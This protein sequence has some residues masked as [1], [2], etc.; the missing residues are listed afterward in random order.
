MYRCMDFMFV[1]ICI[2]I[3]MNQSYS[4]ET[5]R[6]NRQGSGICK[7]ERHISGTRVSPQ[8]MVVTSLCKHL[9]CLKHPGFVFPNLQHTKAAQGR[10][11]LADPPI[12]LKEDHMVCTLP[13][14]LPTCSSTLPLFCPS[15]MTFAHPR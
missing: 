14:S 10:E 5:Y 7:S 4:E 9:K 12:K 6:K 15:R 13:N 2:H 8:T 11:C 3:P 1:Y